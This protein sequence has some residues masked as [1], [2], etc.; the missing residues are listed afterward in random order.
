MKRVLPHIGVL[1]LAVALICWFFIENCIILGVVIVDIF[2]QFC[3]IGR[4]PS[5]PRRLHRLNIDKSAISVAGLSAGADMAA[6]LQLAYSS[7]FAGAAIFAGQAP[8]CAAIRFPNDVLIRGSSPR[9][10]SCP[11]GMT[12]KMDH[13]KN[14]VNLRV[15]EHVH[16]LMLPHAR[17]AAAAGLYDSL[18]HLKRRRIFIF[19]GTRD[20]AYPAVTV[21]ASAAFFR[22][23]GTPSA[24]HEV[25][26]VDVHHALPS[27]NRR[28]CDGEGWAACNWDGAAE[29]LRWI[30]GAG[31]LSNGRD[32]D[33]NLSSVSTLRG[34]LQSFDQ[35]PFSVSGHVH[36]GLADW[37]LLFTPD[38]CWHGAP[39]HIANSRTPG[40]KLVVF[41]HGCSF[42]RPS[43]V[44]EAIALHGGFND[45][46][47]RNR[48]VVLYPRMGRSGHSLH[49]K[50]GCWDSYGTYYGG[51]YDTM[52]AKAY[53]ERDAPLMKAIYNMV[54]TIAGLKLRNTP[55]HRSAATATSRRDSNK[56]QAE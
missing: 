33:M 16:T 30:Y 44:H 14:D 5:P 13:C 3:G 23:V 18:S 52:G 15:D 48:I 1:A 50:L 12:V 42:P 47:V 37:G 7:I 9:C 54:A 24:V 38:N 4:I 36:N 21:N 35:R 32:E 10:E 26:S 20:S 8:H 34:R 53:D 19:R 31:S 43:S 39:D 22:A 51:A 27:V 49:E 55:N 46:A 45:W 29:A 41:L 11:D 2:L 17:A 28:Y 56:P 6:Q 25:V 40:C